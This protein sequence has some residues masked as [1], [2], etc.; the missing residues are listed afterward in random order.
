MPQ[1]EAE[2]RVKEQLVN[3]KSPRNAGWEDLLLALATPWSKEFG[4]VYLAELRNY[5]DKIADEVQNSYRWLTSVTIA[6]TALPP[7]CFA[8][9]LEKWILPES[10]NAHTR[11]HIQRWHEQISTFTEALRIRQRLIEEIA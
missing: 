7:A 6:T 8:A 9:A 2:S 10:S 1:R 4:D 5:L 11:W 3:N